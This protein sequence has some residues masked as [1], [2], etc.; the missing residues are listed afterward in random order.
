[1]QKQITS[2]ILRNPN[3]LRKRTTKEILD[4]VFY[5]IPRKCL[6]SHK[7]VRDEIILNEQIPRKLIRNDVLGGSGRREKRLS[8]E[9]DTFQ[10]S[11]LPLMTSQKVDE[12]SGLTYCNA[13]NQC[14]LPN[15]PVGLGPFGAKELRRTRTD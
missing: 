1:M 6:F 13:L 12:D 2:Q 5:L 8:E 11:Q 3:L 15:K 10:N 9:R 4:F 7:M 14:I